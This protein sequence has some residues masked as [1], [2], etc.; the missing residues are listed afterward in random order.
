MRARIQK[1]GNSLAVRIPKPFIAQV[2]LAENAPID[3]SVIGSS[4]VIE[5]LRERRLE[6]DEL[7]SSI[8]DANLHGEVDSGPSVG[9]EAW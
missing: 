9:D 5:P 2:G 8:T 4:V 7:V 6:L 3:I 1:W